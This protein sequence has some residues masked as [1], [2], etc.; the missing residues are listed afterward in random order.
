MLFER[1]SGLSVFRIRLRIGFSIH[2]VGVCVG[3]VGHGGEG[4]VFV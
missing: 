4:V 3:V 2:M 1:S